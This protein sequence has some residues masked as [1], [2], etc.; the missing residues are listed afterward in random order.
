MDHSL[1]NWK[2]RRLSENWHLKL[3]IRETDAISYSC[4]ND[5]LRHQVPL[6]AATHNLARSQRMSF[7]EA[8]GV[9]K[10]LGRALK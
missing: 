3:S 9:T 7:N 6:V 10:S 1:I 4:G 2:Q 8:L 5:M